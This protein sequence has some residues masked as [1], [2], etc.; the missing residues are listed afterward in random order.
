[1]YS[2]LTSHS[3]VYPAEFFLGQENFNYY[4][5]IYRKK[6]SLNLV[7]DKDYSEVFNSI[8]ELHFGNIDLPGF[9]YLSSE[10]DTIE[11]FFFNISPYEFSKEVVDFQILEQNYDSA[12]LVSSDEQLTEYISRRL[13][14][15]EV[16]HFFLA[17]A[18]MLLIIES[19]IINAFSRK[20]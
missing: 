19:I 18:I 11:E 15:A 1:M 5:D 16:W 14:P 7:G 10:N 2:L 3:K 9:Y 8:E 4:K 13:N 17:I 6:R 20:K 12:T